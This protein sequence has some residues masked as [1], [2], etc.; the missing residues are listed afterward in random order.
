MVTISNVK[1]KRKNYKPK[2]LI[3]NLRIKGWLGIVAVH[4][5]Y[6]T[7]L[8]KKDLERSGQIKI[9]RYGRCCKGGEVNR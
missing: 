5:I 3:Y 6:Q 7:A 1:T 9:V 4:P 8:L 2:T